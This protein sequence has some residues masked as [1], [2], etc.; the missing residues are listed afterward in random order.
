M[1]H[2]NET[3]E[4]LLGF[5]VHADLIR[6][7]VT[8]GS[9]LPV[10]IGVFG[11]WGGGK[12]SIMRMLERD[13]EPDNYTEPDQK[14]KYEKIACLY[15]NGWLFE[16]Y[17]DAKAALLSSILLQLA[18]HKRFGPK[19]RD[20]VTSL[21][22]SVEW[23]RLVRMAWQNVALPAIAA[24]ASGA[25]GLISSV[26]APVI[27][28]A[29]LNVDPSTHTVTA[30]PSSG[31][32]KLEDVIKADKSAASPM[33]VRTFRDRFEAML[34]ETEIESLVI[35]IDDLDRCSPERIIENL[36]AIKLFLNVKRT[37]FVIGADP[38]IV[39]HAIA[40]RYPAVVS[41]NNSDGSAISE[42]IVTDYLEKLIQIPYTL[43]RL[44]PAEV[45]TY[46]VLLFCSQGLDAENFKKCLNA[47]GEQRN[48]NRYSVFGYAAVGDAIKG[49]GMSDSLSKSL[50]FCASIAPLITEGLKGNPRQVKRF[51]NALAFRKQLAKIADLQNVRDDILVKL[52]VLEYGYPTEFRQLFEW[53]STQKG[54]PSQLQILEEAFSEPDGEGIKKAEKEIGSKWVTPFAQRWVIMEPRLAGVDLSDYFW[55]ARDRLES[56]LAGVSFISPVVRRILDDLLSNNA[57]KQKRVIPSVLELSPEERILL[58]DRIRESVLRH[59]T[60]V[61]GYNVLRML[62]ENDVVE[63]T[64]TMAD[65]L[66]NCPA[67]AI[68]PSVGLA[69][70]VLVNEKP[71]LTTIFDPPLSALK[72]TNTKIGKALVKSEERSKN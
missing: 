20:K 11:D 25:T 1:W 66:T 23:M 63:A 10:T 21:I 30:K 17:D 42:T 60:D 12:S 6:S 37:A 43:P 44:S 5:Q 34:A 64:Q 3:T 13:L 28:A 16:G 69:V 14:K 46:M 67:D 24:Y 59:P 18:E 48:Q 47:C 61:E 65:V 29:G 70:M 52:M 53:Q 45:H 7:V 56:T 40:T 9:M 2:D 4:D 68:P 31:D 72:K 19:V 15:F 38:R 33:D 41:G 35:L 54:I 50:T 57:A 55:I 62:I 58:M 8:D 39:R 27:A 26:P 36:E 51:L 49:I 32:D 22:K 71:R